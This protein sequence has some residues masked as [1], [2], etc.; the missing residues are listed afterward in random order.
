MHSSSVRSIFCRFIRNKRYKV[1]SL[2]TRVFIHEP[3]PILSLN[4]LFI[5][6][7]RSLRLAS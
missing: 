5:K 3:R 6:T 1:S 4:R 2:L 7:L